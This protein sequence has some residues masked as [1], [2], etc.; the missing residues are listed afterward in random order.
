MFVSGHGSHI[1]YARFTAALQ[2][3]DL[4]FILRHADG[5]TF[6]LPDAVRVCRLVSE[7][8]PECLEAAALRWIR[9]YAVE[10]PGQCWDDY[11]LIV[12]AFGDL[13]GEPELATGRLLWLCRTRGL[14]R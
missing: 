14:D 5:L 4:G 1:P 8:A 10:A 12:D 6:G 13:P 2:A 11:R 3:G 9:R 7:R